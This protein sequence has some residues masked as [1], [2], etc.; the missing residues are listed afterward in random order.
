V[1]STFVASGLG[2]DQGAEVMVAGTPGEYV[3]R[4][5]RL[6]EDE[7]LWSRLS[8]ASTAFIQRNYSPEIMKQRLAEILET[9]RER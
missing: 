4:I 1:V 7:S 9:E 5:L 6:Y 8:M 2:L 3:E